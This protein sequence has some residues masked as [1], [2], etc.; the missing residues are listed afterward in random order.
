MLDSEPDPNAGDGQRLRFA[1]GSQSSVASELEG[2]PVNGS[3]DI[4]LIGG[5]HLWC[6]RGKAPVFVGATL[7]DLEGIFPPVAPPPSVSR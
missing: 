7:A 1:Q 2:P 3:T 5:W 6:G 4:G